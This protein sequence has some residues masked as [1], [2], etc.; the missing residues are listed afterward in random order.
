MKYYIR[1]RRL[2]WQ[3]VSKEKFNSYLSFLKNTFTEVGV[4]TKEQQNIYLSRYTKVKENE[5]SIIS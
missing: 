2:K 1:A 3:E 5:Q 4:S